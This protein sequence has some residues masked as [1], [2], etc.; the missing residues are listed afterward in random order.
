MLKDSLAIAVSL[1]FTLLVLV[2]VIKYELKTKKT[3]TSC[4]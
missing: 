1:G 4:R 3:Y 2:K